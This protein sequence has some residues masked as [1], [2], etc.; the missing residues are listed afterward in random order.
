MVDSEAPAALPGHHNLPVPLTSLV[1]RGAE[2]QGIAEALRTSRLVTLTGPGG[3]GKTRLALELARRQVG[4]RADGVWLVDLAAGPEAADVAAETAR[5]LDVGSRRGATWTDALVGYLAERDP[6]LVLDNCEHVIDA[7]AELAHTLLA[8]CPDVRIMATS[9]EILDMPGER[10]W[11]LEPLDADHARRLFVQRARARRPEF[12]PDERAD[13]TITRICE[14]LDRLPL[15]I[16]L[17]A[18]RVGVMSAEEI[19][20]GLEARLGELRG[21][22]LARPRHRTVRATVEWSHR[23]LETAEQRALRHLAVFLGGFDAQ[24]G[25]AVAPGLSLDVLARLV[26]KSLVSVSESPA[27]RTRYRLLETVREYA[28]ERLVEAGELEAARQRHLGHFAS[29]APPGP[30]GWPSPAAPRLVGELQDDYENVRAA[31]EFSAASGPCSGMPFLAGVWDLFFMLGQGDGLRLGE[32]LLERCPERN[33][34][35]A[36]VQI[37]IAVLRLMQADVEGARATLAD[38]LELSIELG[39]RA[40]EGWALFFR[41]LAATF[42]GLVDPGREALTRARD[43]HNELGVQVGAGRA[44]AALGLVELSA[45]EPARARELVEEALE[46]QAATGDLW[47]QG[48]C[49]VYLGMIAE[50]T[51][52]ATSQAA[53]HYRQAVD[54]LRPYGSGGPLLPIALALQGGVVGPRDAKRGLRVIA[55]ASAIRARAGGE[56]APIFKERVDRRRSAAAA[57]L[58]AEAPA[59]WAEGTGLLLDEAIGLA[60]GTATARPSRPAGL[61]EREAEVARLVAKGLSNKQIASRLQL[62]VRTIEDHVRHA[63]AKTGLE[64]RTQL[65]TWVSERIP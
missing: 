45:G 51:G 43:L 26:D 28:L 15:A 4:R 32:L 9:R 21:G 30:E 27:G 29:L 49:H 6:L 23:L 36:S 47:S 25:I 8:S 5:T 55:A 1:G 19:L 61:S 64:N 60:F 7:S 52:S 42:G 54:S 50:D 18:A 63:L 62:S 16:E 37:S 34:T 57:V 22:R 14:R 31:L 3:V 65:A 35:R 20:A 38:A 40:L 13:E 39:E 12:M 41:G 10:V 53:A 11:R 46:I 58:G 17:A 59:V 33:R 48:Q 2:L 24:A 56:F 44:I